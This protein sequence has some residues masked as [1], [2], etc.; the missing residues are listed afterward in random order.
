MITVSGAGI[1]DPWQVTY[2]HVHSAAGGRM[3]QTQYHDTSRALLALSGPEA[4]SFLQGLIT[5]DV[6][7]ATDGVTYTAMLSPQGKYLFDFFVV[8]TA[9]GYLLDV[10]KAQADAL[11]LRL[12]MYK[13]RAKVTLVPSAMIVLRGNNDM[14]E[15]GLPDPRHAAMGWR[16]YREV[17]PYPA[18]PAGYF[19]AARV[20]AIVPKT[21]VELLPNDSY[22]LEMGFE[23]LNGVSFR[24]GCYVGQEVTARM[25]HKTELRKGLVRVQID[26]PVPVGCD[27]TMDGRTIG[28]VF[29]QA[30]G[31][32]LAY[33]RHDLAGP[34]MQAGGVPVRLY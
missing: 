2:I 8:K 12:N 27:I 30:N 1:V 17:G 9:D 16:A 24:K 18:L 26:Q 6:K 5:N 13:L 25:K 29:T 11:R 31:Q 34:G 33:L 21:S 20:E 22:I 10:D 19:D 15:D 23:R 32:A 14:P 4:D 28:Q 3:E 7:L